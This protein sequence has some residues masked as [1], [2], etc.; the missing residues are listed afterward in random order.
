[1]ALETPDLSFLTPSYAPWIIISKTVKGPFVNSAHLWDSAQKLA[2]QNDSKKGRYVDP[3]YPEETSPS[4][5]GHVAFP[6]KI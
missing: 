5:L 6:G 4:E 3:S 1:M 2:G